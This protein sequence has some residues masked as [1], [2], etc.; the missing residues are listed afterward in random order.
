MPNP[1]PHAGHS[2]CDQR[3]EAGH[4]EVPTSGSTAIDPVCVMAVTLSSAPTGQI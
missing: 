4:P 2:H 3:A 1:D